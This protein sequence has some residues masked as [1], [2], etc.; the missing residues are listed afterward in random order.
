MAKVPFTIL[1]I[2][3][4]MTLPLFSLKPLDTLRIHAE[5]IRFKLM[6]WRLLNWSFG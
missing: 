4:K 6:V 1:R 3:I 5:L 2:G